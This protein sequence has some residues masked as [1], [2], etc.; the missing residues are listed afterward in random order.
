LTN[1]RSAARKKN[2]ESLQLADE[3]SRELKKEII[4]IT[5]EN[6]EASLKTTRPSIAPEEQARLRKI[7]DEFIGARNGEMP[8]GQASTEVGGRSSLM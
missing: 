4:P 1:L 6:I 8:N 3:G 7:Y 2:A 5:W